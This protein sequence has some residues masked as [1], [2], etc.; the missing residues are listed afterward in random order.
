MSKRTLYKHFDSKTALFGVIIIHTGEKLL[1][2]L[3][4]ARAGDDPRTTLTEFARGYLDLALSPL[5]LDLSRTVI[6]ESK[7]FPRLGRTFHATGYERT[8]EALSQ[9]LTRQHAE[10]TLRVPEPEI[11]ANQFIG[12]CL[13]S[14]RLR[15]YFNLA[16]AA[17]Q[18]MIERWIESAVGLFLRGC[19]Y[20]QLV[21]EVERVPAHRRAAR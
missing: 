13:G 16:V 19:G 10:S 3:Q 20:R 7:R 17:D 6:A 9:F 18:V 1:S 5:G 2:T 14:L 8:P 12:L 15:A 4:T 11:L 21:I